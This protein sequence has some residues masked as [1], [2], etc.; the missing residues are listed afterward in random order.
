VVFDEADLLLEGGFQQDTS[1]ILQALQASDRA[2]KVDIASRELGIT[3]VAYASLPRHLKKAGYQGMQFRLD[4]LFLGY[5][6]I[7]SN[8]LFLPRQ[9][10][11]TSRF[12][13][14]PNYSIILVCQSFLTDFKECRT[15]RTVSL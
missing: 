1:R 10:G 13:L 4:L 2:R 8:C 12:A 14:F 5:S 15:S 11:R 6:F 3:P 9:R 7:S